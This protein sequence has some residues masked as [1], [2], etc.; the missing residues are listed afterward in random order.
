M[1]NRKTAW[2]LKISVKAYFLTKKYKC[3][4]QMLGRMLN[5]LEDKTSLLG[6]GPRK[7]NLATTNLSLRMATVTTYVREKTGRNLPKYTLL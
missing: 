6:R 3:Q 7:L 1:T 2:H 5:P 4:M